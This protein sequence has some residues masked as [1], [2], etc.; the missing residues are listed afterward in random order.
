V[1]TTLRSAEP[2]DL[3]VILAL[4]K[5]LAAYE[6]LEAEVVFDTDQFGGHLF[7]ERS[8]ASVLLAEVDG[9]VAG[10]ALWF[11][12]FSTFLGRSGIWLEDLYVRPV[13]R[14][15]GVGAALLGALRSMTDGRIEWNVLEWNESAVRFY[16]RLGAEP[17]DGWTTYRWLT[18]A[19]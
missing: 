5:E 18:A 10:F 7:G 1:T 15:V 13:H 6:Q 4:V 11:P 8:V 12:S 16:R 2:G 17:V 19:R 3:E 14:G 9:D